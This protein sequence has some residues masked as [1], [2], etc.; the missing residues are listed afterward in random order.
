[1][2]AWGYFTPEFLIKGMSTLSLLIESGCCDHHLNYLASSPDS[3]FQQWSGLNNA[4]A[5]IHQ[6]STIDNHFVDLHH[7]ANNW[8]SSHRTQL[9]RQ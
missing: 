6:E 5:T 3:W 9:L 1:M 4:L 7:L 8:C 2:L